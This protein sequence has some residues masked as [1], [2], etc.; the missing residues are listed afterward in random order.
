MC[1]G[2]ELR[3]IG[4]LSKMVTT[5]DSFLANAPGVIPASRGVKPNFYAH[6][7]VS[8]QYDC[9]TNKGLDPP[10]KANVR[11]DLYHR[12]SGDRLL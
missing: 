2:V 4:I 5:E 8:H 9:V 11:Q 3:V 10:K 7:S 12:S 6:T 1:G